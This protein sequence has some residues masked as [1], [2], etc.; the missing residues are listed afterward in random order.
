MCAFRYKPLLEPHEPWKYWL[1][2]VAKLQAHNNKEPLPA[3][4][5]LRMIDTA[6]KSARQLPAKSG[7]RKGYAMLL[8]SYLR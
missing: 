7:A 4:T 8:I 6:V 3:T 5:D 1:L 2:P